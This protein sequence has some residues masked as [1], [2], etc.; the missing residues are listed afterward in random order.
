MGKKTSNTVFDAA[1]NYV[2]T[3]AEF[4]ILCDV[5]PADRAAAIASSL[6]TVTVTGGDFSIADGLISGRRL[7]VAAKAGESGIADGNHNHTCLISGTELLL[8]TRSVTTEAIENGDTVNVAAW[9]YELRD[10]I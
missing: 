5:E 9:G 6:V 3:N 8:V 2:I 1:L 4:M 10:P 7:N